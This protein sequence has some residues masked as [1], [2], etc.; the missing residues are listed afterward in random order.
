MSPGIINGLASKGESS[1]PFPLGTCSE[2]NLLAASLG[3][4]LRTYRMKRSIE[5]DERPTKS[6]VL[7][8]FPVGVRRRALSTPLD[9]SQPSPRETRRRESSLPA[10]G[11]VGPALAVIIVTVNTLSRI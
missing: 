8:L 1:L 9:E 7:C 4:N 2:N 10:G 11:K 5:V 6:T 3:G